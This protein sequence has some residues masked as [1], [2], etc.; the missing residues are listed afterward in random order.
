MAIYSWHDLS[1]S[2]Q[3]TVLRLARQGRRHPDRKVAAAAEQWAKEKLGRDGGVG[4]S[5]GGIIVG[6]LF[7][8]GSSIGEGVRDYR[9]AKRIMRVADR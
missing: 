6:L 1:W 8:D 5:I 7:G 2:E 9:A 4:G 3:R